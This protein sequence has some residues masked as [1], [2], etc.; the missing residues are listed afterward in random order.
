MEVLQADHFNKVNYVFT[1]EWL[2]AY[3]SPISTDYIYIYIVIKV[4]S[5]KGDLKSIRHANRL[6]GI[7]CA[8]IDR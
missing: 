8:T 5:S 3:M 2:R 6:Y 7:S 1:L 4:N